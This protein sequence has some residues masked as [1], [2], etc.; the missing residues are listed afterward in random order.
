MYRAT[1]SNEPIGGHQ[2]DN[3][4][5]N[6]GKDSQG[7]LSAFEAGQLLGNLGR[8]TGVRVSTEGTF[9]SGEAGYY[10]RSTGTLHINP[11]ADT[12]QQLAAVFTHELTHHLE[13]TE[14]YAKLRDMLVNRWKADHS[15]YD[16]ILEKIREYR[17]HGVNINREGAISELV[18]QYAQENLFTNASEVRAVAAYDLSLAGRI[19]N[20]ISRKIASVT[21]NMEKLFLRNAEH[22][23]T[24]AIRQAQTAESRLMEAMDA[25]TK[26]P[27]GRTSTQ[28]D[29]KREQGGGYFVDVTDDILRGRSENDIP[30]ILYDIV[31]TKFVDAVYTNGQYI[32]I[33]RRTAKEWR[34]SRSAEALLRTDPQ[35]Y[36]DKIRAF[37]SAD[38][39][40]KAAKDYVGEAIKHSRKDNF[41]EFA[42]G[43][44]DF[45]VGQNGYT[46]DIVVGTTAGGEAILYDVVNIHS[47]KIAEASAT[48]T[49]KRK[50][51]SQAEASTTNSVSYS[52]EKSNPQSGEKSGRQYS[53]KQP[54]SERERLIRQQKRKSAARHEIWSIAGIEEKGY[55]ELILDSYIG[56]IRET[57]W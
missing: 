15:L 42:R 50:T 27:A 10:D 5:F 54:Q 45:R 34:R 51:I 16:R 28:Y 9:R 18:A 12:R 19:K 52:S 38:E 37:S 46:A 13:G 21:G 48:L 31:R 3:A 4:M 55:T 57:I 36:S 7:N 56:L 23:Y 29:M 2:T 1:E 43:T 39:L 44:V 49:S 32:G 6:P 14:S 8:A 22:L 11:Q 26:A 25:A 47:K 41:V 20:W 24:Q 30:A 17:G 33:D 40:L 53:L 35:G